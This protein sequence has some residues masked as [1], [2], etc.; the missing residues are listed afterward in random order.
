MPVL[1]QQMQPREDETRALLR[2]VAA[3]SENANPIVAVAAVVLIYTMYNRAEHLGLW[4]W[5][6]S[7]FAV[8]VWRHVVSRR[9]REHSTDADTHV[10]RRYE[11]MM[12]AGTACSSV[13]MGSAF[14]LIA[15]NGDLYA[16]MIVTLISWVHMIAVLLYLTPRAS[17]RVIRTAGNLGQGILFW[18]GVGSAE[19][20]HWEVLVVYAGLFWCGMVFS[21]EQLRQFRESLRVRNENAALLEQ[22]EADRKVIQGALEEAR[23][24]NASK[25]RFLAAAS[26]D[27]RQP[28]HAL[29]MFL[30]TLGFHV[31]TDDA[32]RLLGRVKDTVRVLEEQFNSLLDMSRFDAGAVVA[33]PHGFRLDSLVEKIVEEFR[34]QAEGKGLAISVTA[35]PALAHSDPLL[36]G[37]LLRNLIDN[38]VHYTTYGRIA[39]QVQQAGGR[40]LL[41]VHDTGP[42]IAADQQARIFDEYVQL[43]NPGRQRQRGVG[44]GL[45]IVKRID[46]LLGLQLQL[47]STPGTGSRFTVSV[48]LAVDG[49]MESVPA[50][51]PSEALTFR[52]SARIWLLDDDPVVLESLQAQLQAWGAQV[53]AFASPEQLLDTLRRKGTKPDWI[54]TDDMLGTGLSGLE[55]ARIAVNELGVARAC[56]ITGNT[57]PARLDELRRSGFPVIVK[58]AT[59]EQLIALLRANAG[60]RLPATAA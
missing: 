48:P 5:A 38:A 29:T 35:E 34:P 44:L 45:A 28:L 25:N 18:L 40:L 3:Q 46:Q 2:I 23:L 8:A 39:V 51:L 59:L 24:A 22:V 57:E 33:N 52:T 9:I 56:V 1:N 17:D 31:T 58:P 20:P 27:L 14:W 6:V 43:D 4:I 41:T 11:W 32:R 60:S 47:Q 54:L 36:L 13:I 49:I 30:G 37:R 55:T 16:R 53:N 50:G 7:A 26:H 10:L 42:G 19:P 12:L 21:R 15:A